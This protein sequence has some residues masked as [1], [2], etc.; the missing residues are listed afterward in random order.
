[1]PENDNDIPPIIEDSGGSPDGV[2]HFESEHCWCRPRIEMICPECHADP[3]RRTPCF[4]CH[5]DGCVEHNGD[6]NEAKLVI[7]RYED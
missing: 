2:P 1:M 7:H 4:L 5:G 3:D 6:P